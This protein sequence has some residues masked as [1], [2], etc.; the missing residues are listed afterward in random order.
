MKPQNN[1]NQINQEIASL[2]AKSV[3]VILQALV[4]IV[5][6]CFSIIVLFS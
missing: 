4:A 5:S 3:I 6:I 2:N 1:Q